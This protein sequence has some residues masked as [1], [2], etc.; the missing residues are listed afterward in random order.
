M[1]A[2]QLET[3]PAK[4]LK[5]ITTYVTPEVWA[6]IQQHAKKENRTF[7]NMAATF[8]ARC[9]LPPEERP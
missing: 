1:Y 2:T 4:N 8:L 6:L 9:V 3:L 5:R 7:S